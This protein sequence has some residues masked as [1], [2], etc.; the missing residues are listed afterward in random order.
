MKIA[1]LSGKGG[2]GKT[3]VSNNLA[4]LMTEATII[5]CDVEEPNSFIFLKPTVEK[6]E[7]ICVEYPV[8]DDLRCKHCKK[9]AAFCHYNAII[10]GT[11][12]T[13][14]MK[15]I[16]HDCGGCAIVCPESAIEYQTRTIGR[17]FSGRAVTGNKMVYGVLNPGEL[18]GVR[19]INQVKKIV[20]NDPI[21]I[22]DSP[23]GT[24]CSTVAA[25]EGCDFAIIVTEPTP[26]GV[27][28]MKMVVEMLRSMSIPMAV[29]INKAGLGDDEVYKYCHD[30]K[31][32]I[33]GEI[34]FDKTIAEAYAKG[35]LAVD[36]SEEKRIS[37]TQLWGAIHGIIEVTYD[38]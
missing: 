29:V 2:T 15:E 28:D 4:A 36:V 34:S 21:V 33:I 1:V 38:H 3:T 27:S 19:I 26:F 35:E 8:V 5:D 18:S 31:L 37:F 7:D 25:V 23:P 13:L 9:C 22:V 14:P 16:C 32:E 20:Q 6:E 24:S 12:L 11:L 10:A 17:I 30:E